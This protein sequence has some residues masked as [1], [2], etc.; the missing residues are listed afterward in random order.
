MNRIPSTPQ[1]I[2]FLKSK[3]KNEKNFIFYLLPQHSI[4]YI[5]LSNLKNNH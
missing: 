3:A 5:L 2:P 4:Y 1:K